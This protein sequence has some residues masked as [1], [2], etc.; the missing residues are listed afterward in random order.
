MK[1]TEVLKKKARQGLTPGATGVVVVQQ[2]RLVGDAV[3]M[4]D[5]RNISS[6]VVVDPQGRAMGLMCDRD[7]VH[8]IA[9]HGASALQMR[10]ADVM[11]APPPSC[12][13]DM[14]VSQAL[15][16]MTL[17]RVRHLVVFGEEDMLGIVSI[18][19]LVKVR[20]EEA[21]IEGRVL[22]EMALGRIAGTG[23]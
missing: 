17:D 23:A 6:V 3:R 2:N 10:T 20:L 8:A 5:E 4:F 19:D 15:A 18:G 9:R 16:R 12:T 11:M 13:P 7:V 1:I 22:R 21:E 14:T